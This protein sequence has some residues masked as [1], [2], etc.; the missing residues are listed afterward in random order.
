MLRVPSFARKKGEGL[1]AV[2]RAISASQAMIE[3]D[4]AG[5]VL[6]ANGN[7]LA[8]F[9]YDLSDVVGKHHRMFVESAEAA[10]EKYR[11][12]WSALAAGKFQAGTF[13]YVGKRQQIVWIEGSYNPVMGGLRGRPLKVVVIATDL[14]PKF[15]PVMR[16]VLGLMCGLMRP[17]FPEPVS[18]RTRRA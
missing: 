13:K 4:V 14:S 2:S 8:L 16:R 9:G 7:F 15:P 1:E 3:F 11:Q 5:N 18:W 6:T 12:F 17:V 10:S